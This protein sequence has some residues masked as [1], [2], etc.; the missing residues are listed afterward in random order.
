MRMLSEQK[1]G[2][3]NVEIRGDQQA[4]L[5]LALSDLSFSRPGWDNAIRNVAAQFPLGLTML[6]RYQ[7]DRAEA[8]LSGVEA[9]DASKARII[10]NQRNRMRALLSEWED[11]C[12][13]RPILIGNLRNRTRKELHPGRAK[14]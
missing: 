6:E 7:R 2:P 3:Q 13:C 8:L 14:K 5:M 10:E 1:Q 12:L 11:R 4:V 9:G